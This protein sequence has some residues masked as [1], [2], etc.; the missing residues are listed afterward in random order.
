MIQLLQSTDF[1]LRIYPVEEKSEILIKMLQNG[2]IDATLLANPTLAKGL[3]F[4]PVF[5]DEFQLAVYRDHPLADIEAVDI[6]TLN[7]EAMLFL[8]KGH[9]LRDQVAALKL[10]PGQ[11]IECHATGLETLRQMVIA[12]LGISIMPKIASYQNEPGICY[13]PFKAPAPARTIGIAYRS[14]SM[15]TPYLSPFEQLIRQ[16]W[17]SL[18]SH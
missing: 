2:E 10:N 6:Q 17:A 13:I 15:I 4:I 5:Q 9:C 1:P 3:E 14:G 12:G 11:S 16:S 7:D 18:A 8:E